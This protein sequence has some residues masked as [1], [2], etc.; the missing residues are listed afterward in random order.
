LGVHSDALLQA[1]AAQSARLRALADI[2]VVPLLDAARALALLDAGRQDQ[3]AAVV[4]QGLAAT[5][6]SSGARSFPAWAWA[7]ARVA[8]GPDPGP[9]V[10]AY[11]DYAGLVARRR[12][13]S[14]ASV[15][16]AARSFLLNERLR[17]DHDRLSRDL[18]VDALT[19]LQNRRAF[20]QWLARPSSDAVAAL[21]LVDLD[22]FKRVNDT[23]GHSTGDEVLRRVGR[24]VADHVRP[25][26]LALR[27]GGDEFA[28]VL[29]QDASQVSV[30]RR[31]AEQ[32]RN[33]I[34]LAPWP[35][36]GPGLVVGASVGVAVGSLLDGA[37]HL[38][39]LADD[40]LYQAKSDPSGVVLNDS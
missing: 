19:G 24:I 2:E 39:E 31:R 27:H 7:M 21:L 4:A 33:A 12:W 37:G 35:D 26:D 25:G 5:S 16:V 3:A 1:A 8:A 32:L 10:Q 11:A 14:R 29:E 20:E 17:A 36:V 22:G 15:L 38:Y 9:A 28:V 13:E 18:Y 34:R 23:Y 6:A 30:V 40:A